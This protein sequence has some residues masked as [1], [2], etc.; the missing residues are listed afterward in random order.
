MK[1]SLRTL[2]GLGSLGLLTTNCAKNDAVPTTECVHQATVIGYT[3][4][5]AQGYVL[6]LESPRDTVN[7]FNLPADLVPD[8]TH[9]SYSGRGD[10]LY[11]ATS[12][13][14][15][16]IGYTTLAPADRTQSLCNASVY[17]APWLKLTKGEEIK[18]LCASKPDSLKH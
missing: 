4:C 7:C 13:V 11:A 6:A 12:F 14:H 10:G 16:T 1:Y 2:L 9:M 17:L 18:I 3:P 8:A 5:G 15:L